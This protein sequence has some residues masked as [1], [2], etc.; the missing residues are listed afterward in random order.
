MP[1]KLRT[2]DGKDKLKAP[3]PQ[4]AGIVQII[5]DVL[6]AWE[7]LDF[8]SIIKNIPA[9]ITSTQQ[10]FKRAQVRKAL[11]SGVYSGFFIHVSDPN[12]PSRHKATERGHWK[13]A[14]LSYYEARRDH[15]KNLPGEP[16]RRHHEDDEA[17]AEVVTPPGIDRWFVTGVAL[18][19]CVVGFVLGTGF[20]VLIS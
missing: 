10:I 15:I 12:N 7:K 6:D 18:T 16:R 9:A 19:A 13:I 3:R 20:G 8:D 5:Y 4:R 1:K 2:V 17:E 14:P 11:Y